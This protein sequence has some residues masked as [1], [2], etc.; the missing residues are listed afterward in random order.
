M[1]IQYIFLTFKPFTEKCGKKR[2]HFAKKT[3][4]IE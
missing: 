1:D 3:L 4:N 2:H